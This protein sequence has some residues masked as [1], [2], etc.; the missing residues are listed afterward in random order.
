MDRSALAGWTPCLDSAIRNGLIPTS[1][2]FSGMFTQVQL[3][4]SEGCRDLCLV[5][6]GTTWSLGSKY[7]GKMT[8][9]PTDSELILVSQSSW[10]SRCVLCVEERIG[11]CCQPVPMALSQG[12]TAGKGTGPAEPGM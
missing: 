10:D 2:Q 8:P 4:I 1:V 12:I 7:R 5:L 6:S 9:K 3:N 11:W